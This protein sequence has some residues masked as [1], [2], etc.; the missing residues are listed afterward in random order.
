MEDFQGP[1]KVGPEKLP[2]GKCHPVHRK[3]YVCL[4]PGTLLQSKRPLAVVSHRV[5]VGRQP[6]SKIYVTPMSIYFPCF[7]HLI[8]HYWGNILYPKP[9]AMSWLSARQDFS[10]TD[11]ASTS[12]SSVQRN[13]QRK[14]EFF[15]NGKTSNQTPQLSQRRP[16]VVVDAAILHRQQ[17]ERDLP[18]Q[19]RMGQCPPSL[20]KVMLL[21]FLITVSI[22]VTLLLVP[23]LYRNY[24]CH[25]FMR[26]TNFCFA[27]VTQLRGLSSRI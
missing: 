5:F 26:L 16:S 10:Q 3:Q 13:G 14:K 18:L 2:H 20:C 17:E 9:S 27:T 25:Y 19:M 23:L 8:L 11:L 15:G 7:L 4:A 22:N 24:H 1:T 12:S 21:Q 6:P